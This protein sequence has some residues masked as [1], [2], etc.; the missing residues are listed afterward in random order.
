MD[1]FS[2][3]FKNRGRR[4]R[5]IRLPLIIGPEAIH[6]PDYDRLLTLLL[7]DDK[8]L[9]NLRRNVPLMREL[10]HK[11][12]TMKR[13]ALPL[14]GLTFALTL[15]VLAA[16]QDSVLRAREGAA[17]LLRSKYDD[18]IA[19]FDSALG[20][21]DLADVTRANIL[22]DRGVAKW[23]L[24]QTKEA[25]TDFNSSIK[26]FPDYAIVYNN[27]GNALL[28]LGEAEQ[29]IVDFSRAIELAPGYGAAFNN[30]GNALLSLG[31]GEEAMKDFRKAVQLMPTNA[32]PFNGRGRTHAMLGR[33]F[34]GLRDFSRALAL[35][36]KYSGA[37]Q[38]RGEAFVKLDRDNDAIGDYTDLIAQEPEVAGLYLARGEAYARTRRY[39]AAVR[40][41]NKAITLDGAL[42]E[43]YRAR[44]EI[45][46]TVKQADKARDDFSVALSIAPDDA[47]A[48]TGR[49]RTYFAQGLPEEALTDL[50]KALSVS[51]EHT[52]ALTLR[53]QIYESVGRAEDAAKDYRAALMTEPNI[54]VAR[55]ALQKMG[56]ELPP[57]RAREFIGKPVK[58]W[59]VSRNAEGQFEA[60]NRRYPKLRIPLEM[61]GEGTPELLDW[62]LMRYSLQGIGLLRYRAGTLPE[63]SASTYEYSVVIDLWKGK[64]AAVEPHSWGDQKAR[65]EWKQASVSVT[66]PDGVTNEVVLR[67]APTDTF[68]EGSDYWQND[69]WWSQGTGGPPRRQA[70]R[71]PQGGGGGLFDWLFR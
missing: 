46:Y 3:P 12:R 57:Q 40:D 43:A 17:N 9:H 66:D 38:N 47:S 67:K 35:N 7:P 39:N 23:R 25:I 48:L 27:R 28:D 16:T 60:T 5:C 11:R 44:G 71:R 64:V 31:R 10:W 61:Y 1:Q 63:K 26:L 36:A 49:A 70:P 62:T 65:W 53:G 2:V 54:A 56:Q 33:P 42:M 8:E 21:G 45:Y 30:R 29:A 19:S 32:V 50:D 68:G 52:D 59:Q 34:A 51:S 6:N 41:F 13:A 55:A 24:K 69:S 14:I 58:G 15:P 20:A 22:N 18:A 4:F 37:R